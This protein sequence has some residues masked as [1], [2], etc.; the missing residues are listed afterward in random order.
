M[1][2][3]EQYMPPVQIGEVMRGL[4]IGR[5]VASNNDSYK[6]GELLT[7]PIG[8]QDYCLVDGSESWPFAPL[9]Q[10]PDVPLTLFMGAAGMTGLTAYFGLLEVGQAKAGETLLVSAAAGAT[11]SIVGQIG[12]LKGLRV[13]GIAGGAEKCK[14][15]TDYFGFDAAVDYK[16]TDWK[17]QLIAA[18]PDGIDISFENVGGEIMNA[19]ISRFNMHARMVLCGLISSYNDTGDVNARA[20][21]V[22]FLMKRASLKGFIVSDYFAKFQQATAELVGWYLSGSIK[23]KETV[24]EGLEK[25]P[26]ALNQLFSGNNIGKLMIK[27]RH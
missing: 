19:A 22:P 2:D 26:E 20:N 21:L 18:T 27:L 10:L 25:A 7:G 17:E 5:V 8:W 12:K 4:G 24:L 3:V 15:L 11:G 13:V 1:T 6:I 23:T 9:P 16:A 14:I